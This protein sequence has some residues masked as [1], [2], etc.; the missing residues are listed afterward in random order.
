MADK[1]GI[2]I[3]NQIRRAG[4]NNAIIYITTSDD[5]ALDAYSVHAV[6]YLLKP[7]S[8]HSFF[9]ALDYALSYAEVQKSPT[10]AIKTRNVASASILISLLKLSTSSETILKLNIL[11][12]PHV[13]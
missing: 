12:T 4:C 3:G 11:K 5:F 9:E 6:R 13:Y 7:I 2:D 1:N 10:Y 8:E